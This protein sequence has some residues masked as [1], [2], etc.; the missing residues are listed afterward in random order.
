MHVQPSGANYSP[1][2]M[3]GAAWRT[4]NV[5]DQ[6]KTFTVARRIDQLEAAEEGAPLHRCG[7]I[8]QVVLANPV[9]CSAAAQRVAQRQPKTQGVRGRLAIYCGIRLERP[10]MGDRAING[11]SKATNQPKPRAHRWMTSCSTKP[12]VSVRIAGR[13][14]ARSCARSTRAERLSQRGRTCRRFKRL[15]TIEE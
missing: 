8:V 14:P 2:S 3:S 10:G 11:S 15:G 6:R 9:R 7:P 1:A 4:G 13:T 5:A 12:T